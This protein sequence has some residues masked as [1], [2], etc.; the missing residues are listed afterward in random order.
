MVNEVIKS[1]VRVNTEVRR[2]GRLFPPFIRT[3]IPVAQGNSRGGMESARRWM[4]SFCS[5]GRER[6][7]TAADSYQ[8][9]F[10]QRTSAPSEPS[11]KTP[12]P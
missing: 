5:A 11:E 8:L 6:T 10:K 2:G 4:W 1:V 7:G 12:L 9:T 3:V